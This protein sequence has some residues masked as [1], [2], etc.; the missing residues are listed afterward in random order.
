[1]IMLL[2]LL[3][4]IIDAQLGSLKSILNAT[5]GLEINYFIRLKGFAVGFCS[6]SRI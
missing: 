5:S 3:L 1:M 4:F 6:I 2:L